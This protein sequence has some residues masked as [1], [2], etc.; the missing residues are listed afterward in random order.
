MSKMPTNS[1]NLRPINPPTPVF[2][3]VCACCKR[4]HTSSVDARA[5]L[6]AKAGTFVCAR[7]GFYLERDDPV[8]LAKLQEET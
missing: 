1:L 3:F 8:F 5:V 6:K 4:P 2:T 7:C